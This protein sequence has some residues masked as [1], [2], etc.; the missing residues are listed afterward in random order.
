MIINKLI[1]E[2]C[3][4]AT[5]SESKEEPFGD[6]AVYLATASEGPLGIA[7]LSYLAAKDFR[8]TALK[9]DKQPQKL[10][11]SVSRLEAA[12][13]QKVDSKLMMDCATRY[14]Q[15][16]LTAKANVEA[17]VSSLH[18]VVCGWETAAGHWVFRVM[19]GLPKSTFLSPEEVNEA[20]GMAIQMHISKHPHEQPIL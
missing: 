8:K 15:R 19:P 12:L 2:K 9:A 16:T 7:P 10:N 4:W 13:V 18:L 14:V 5:G 11:A 20:L 1:L 17:K 3:G 6:I